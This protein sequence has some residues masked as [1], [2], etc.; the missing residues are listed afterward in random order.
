MALTILGIV[1]G[2]AFIGKIIFQILLDG[3]SYSENGQRPHVNFRVRYFL[4]YDEITPSK[5]LWMKKTCNCLYS[6]FIVSLCLYFIIWNL[7]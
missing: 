1:C 4:A 5:Y 6:I 7:K 2:I 3:V